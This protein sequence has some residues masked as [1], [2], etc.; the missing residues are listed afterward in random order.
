MNMRQDDKETINKIEYLELI[1]LLNYLAVLTRPDILYVQSR[2]AQRCSNPTRKDLRRVMR[3]FQYINT[4]KDKVLTFKKGKPILTAYVD[5][6]HI[7][8]QDG[9]S[10][11]GYCF[12]LGKNDGCFY[13]KSS[14]MKI[15]TPAGSTESEYVALYEAATEAK[16]L[17]DL[18]HEIG[19]PQ[20][21]AVVI[22]EDN[23]S[24]IQMIHNRG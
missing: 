11:M 12:S 13:S 20:D 6:S 23:T 21:E 17:R 3:I 18:L 15:V 16:F 14:K 1:G 24:V 22:N 7:Q 5:A 2:C 9:K 4:T 10:H 19:F 8:Y